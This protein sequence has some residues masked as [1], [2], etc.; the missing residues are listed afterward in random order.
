MKKA[1]RIGT[2]RP[3][4]CQWISHEDNTQ[5]YNSEVSKHTSGVFMHCAILELITH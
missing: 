5:R 1:K 2:V 3:A 4:G